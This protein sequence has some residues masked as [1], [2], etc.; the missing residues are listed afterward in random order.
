VPA[1][2]CVALAGR[3][4]TGSDDRGPWPDPICVVP[5]GANEGGDVSKMPPARLGSARGDDNHLLPMHVAAPARTIVERAQSLSVE[6]TRS[7]RAQRKDNS[8]SRYCP[9]VDIVQRC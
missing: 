2:G 7:F 3:V 6:P 8:A 1:R 5:S 9:M 4:M